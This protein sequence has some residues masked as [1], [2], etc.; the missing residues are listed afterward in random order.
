MKYFDE[1]KFDVK[2]RLSMKRTKIVMICAAVLASVSLISLTA[3]GS[4]EEAVSS[5]AESNVISETSRKPW[6]IRTRY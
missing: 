6:Y 2:E 4:N 3:C 5:T 1:N